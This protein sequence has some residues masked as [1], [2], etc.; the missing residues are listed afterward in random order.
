MS[1]GLLA[2][3]KKSLAETDKSVCAGQISIQHQRL[4]ALSNALCRAIRINAHDAHKH[5][6][7]C[8][9]WGQR[10]SPRQGRLSYCQTRDPVV[11]QMIGGPSPNDACLS[12]QTPHIF[13]GWEGTRS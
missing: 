13:L 5:V 10:Q 9:L 1:L 2:A 11:D 3:T 7:P 12:A 8:V 4:L 6:R